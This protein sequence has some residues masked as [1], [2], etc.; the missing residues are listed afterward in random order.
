MDDTS[1]AQVRRKQHQP[2]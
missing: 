2:K 1:S